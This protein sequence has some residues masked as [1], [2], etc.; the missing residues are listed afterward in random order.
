LAKPI[1]SAA[2][3]G[4]IG[5]RFRRDVKR[6]ADAGLHGALDDLPPAE[7]ERLH[8]VRAPISGNGSVA[9]LPPSAADRLYAP[10]PE[11]E[12]ASTTPERNSRAPRGEPGP[13]GAGPASPN[14]IEI[15]GSGSGDTVP[16]TP[17]RT[18]KP[19]LRGNQPG[20]QAQPLPAPAV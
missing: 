1:A 3:V 4:S 16:R 14:K 10:R 18:T 13:A 2:I 19:G 7:F 9:E 17:T 6:F 11:R 15:T 20:S 8:A 12:R 5:N